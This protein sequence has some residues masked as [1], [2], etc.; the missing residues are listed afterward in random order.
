MASTTKVMTGL[1]AIERLDLH[2]RVRIRPGPA[3]IGEESLRLRVGEQLTVR[4][5]LEGMLLKSA[6]DAA[7]ALAEA[8]DGTEAAFVRRMNAR[9]RQLGMTSTRYVTSYGL[10]RP[11]H[12]TSARDLARLW[13]VAMR[14]PAFRTLSGMQEA[15]L[16]GPAAFRHFEHT[17]KLLG[18]YRWV[19]GGKTGFTNRAGRCLVV[20]AQRGG[21]TLV[22]AVLGSPDAFPDV[23]ALLE[24]GFTQMVR[25]RLAEAGE[26]VEVPTPEA[27]GPPARYRFE[28]TVDALVPRDQLAKV[29]LTVKAGPKPVGVLVA[30]SRSS[31]GP[32]LA[33]RR[34]R[35]GPAAA[36][37]GAGRH[38]PRG[39]R[40]VPRRRC[41]RRC[42]L[43]LLPVPATPN[44][45]KC[46]SGG[47]RASRMPRTARIGLVA[48]TSGRPTVPGFARDPTAVFVPPW[49]H[50]CSTGFACAPPVFDTAAPGG[51]R[52]R[53][54]PG[55]CADRAA[56][57]T[58]DRPAQG[59]GRG[60]FPPHLD[61][62]R[63]G[64]GDRFRPPGRPDRQAHDPRPDAQRARRSSAPRST[65]S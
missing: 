64:H 44:L 20:S 55:R 6:N 46:C 60:A 8:V 50:R 30:G 9:A 29:H 13:N 36:R 21:R 65:G 33:G 25:A 11:G 16:P 52:G 48:C 5:L 57:A 22:A 39:D 26:T 40:P 10:D 23:R 42:R 17:N 12:A 28:Q 62:Q 38:N 4:D 43:A 45:R 59:A 61:R 35:G 53:A 18:S 56:D 51:L 63:R 19:L 54:H 24:Y 37:T 7:V 32:G 27:G 14:K 15:T 49:V 2:Q 3:A 58:A 31:R 34:W 41:R 47:R 1:L